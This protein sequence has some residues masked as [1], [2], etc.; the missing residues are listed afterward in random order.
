MVHPITI[1]GAE[2][3]FTVNQYTNTYICETQEEVLERVEEFM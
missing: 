1:K 3:G 2:N